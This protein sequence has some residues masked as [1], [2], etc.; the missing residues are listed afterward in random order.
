MKFNG[1]I[2]HLSVIDTSATDL[3]FDV[4]RSRWNTRNEKP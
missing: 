1:R 4:K 3:I 2:M